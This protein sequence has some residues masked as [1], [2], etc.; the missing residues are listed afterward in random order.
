MIPNK[1]RDNRA[2]TSY[3]TTKI[4]IENDLNETLRKNENNF[5]KGLSIELNK[6]HSQK[7]NIKFDKNY[8]N[9]HDISSTKKEDSSTG[10]IS[11]F[12]KVQKHLTSKICH[13]I[14]DSNYML[15]ILN[16]F[17]KGGKKFYIQNLIN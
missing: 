15:N 1:K 6:S 4:N 17:K 7:N 9:I 10:T 11:K 14:N 3:K 8:S 12:H 2:S 5:F 16:I 13:K